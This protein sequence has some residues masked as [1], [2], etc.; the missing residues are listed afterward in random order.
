MELIRMGVMY[1]SSGTSKVKKM[2]RLKIGDGGKDPYLFSTNNF[3]GRQTWEFD[4][5]AGTAEE[6]AQVEAARQD[7]YQNRFKLKA[8]ADR[9]WRFQIL[10]ENEFKQRI[11]SVKIEDG[12]E[13]GLEKTT[14]TIKRAIHYLSALQTSDGHWPAYISGGLF[15]VPTLVISLYVIGHLDSALSE[16]HQKEILRFIYYHQNEDGGWGLHIESHSSMFCTTLNY[17]CMRILGEGPNGGHNNA[18]A[19]GRKWIHEHGSV[20]H[21][22]QWGKF[23]LAV[24]GV[25]DWCGNDPLPPEFWMLPKFFPMHP[26]KMWCYCR[27]LYMPMSYIYGKRFTGPITP[28][29]RD[30]REE[31]FNEPYDKNSWKKARHK[32]A[33]EDL[34]SPRHWIQDLIWDSTYLFTEPLLTRWPFNK[35]REKALQLTMEHIHYEDENSRYMGTACL[36]KVLCMMA[37]AVEDSNGEAIKKHLARVP[38]YLWLS[39]DGMTVQTNGSQTWDASFIVQALLATNLV[40]EYG[41][42]LTKA[43]DFIKKSQVQNNPSGDF[44]RMYRHISKGTW[45]FTHQDHGWQVSDCTAESLI[46]CLLLS[47]MSEEIVGQKIETQNLYDAVDFLISLQSK[48]GGITAWEP[49]QSETWLELLNPTEMFSDIIIE[50]EYVE[51]TGVAILALVTFKKEYPNYKEKDV[52]NFIAKAVQYLENE[53]STNG[54]WH[55]KW[56]ICYI[57]SSYFALRGLNAAGKT[58]T[59]SAVI[60]K[61]VKFLLSIQNEDGGW[62][63]S[64]LSCT[65]KMYVPL[66]GNRSN[67]AQTAWALM[68]LIHAGQADRDSIPLH[69]AAKLLINSQ[70][71]SGDWPQ[72]EATGAF[73]NT[74]VLHYPLYRNAFPLWALAQYRTQVLLPSTS[75]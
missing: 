41:P 15:F 53:Q 44:K 66:E 73:L 57:Y 5:E 48:N 21:I 39:E 59:N 32:C 3:V 11:D 71:E 22:S 31:L 60:R 72:E 54:S 19:K 50:H 14:V 69:R 58:Y 55:G 68:A 56:G 36:E 1:L 24:L 67:I 33:K 9:V 12:E 52:D 34:Y 7:F 30:L 64:Y 2:W 43:H 40:E 13:I 29:I 74:G 35:I 18:C 42:T 65:K 20:T 51:C 27:F 62:G 4:S 16:E 63:E 17:I 49:S 61:V 47:T 75:A 10:R 26:G 45:P 38:D 25:V 70:L 46:C 8:C 23:W 6:R 37:C 28:L